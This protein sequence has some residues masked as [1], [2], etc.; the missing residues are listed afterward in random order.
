MDCIN[1][2]SL[3]GLFMYLFLK[4]EKG[5]RIVSKNCLCL[6]KWLRYNKKWKDG[7]GH[8]SYFLESK[9][10][11]RFDNC[12]QP[13]RKFILR[14]TN[15]R[16]TKTLTLKSKKSEGSSE[17]R[18]TTTLTCCF[19]IFFILWPLFW[20]VVSFVH[21]WLGRYSDQSPIQQF[22]VN[23]PLFSVLHTTQNITSTQLGMW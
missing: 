2:S 11:E 4:E 13:H 23:S 17:R 7:W 21:S 3:F 10:Q 9:W 5:I 15:L 1:T 8:N 20:L 12:L 19:K 14:F 22:S 16:T 18:N 6:Y